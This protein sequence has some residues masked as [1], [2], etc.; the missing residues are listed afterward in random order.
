MCGW[1]RRRGGDTGDGSDV[2]SPPATHAHGVAV[3]FAQRD[4][5][6][7]ANLCRFGCPRL[8]RT[9]WRRRRCEREAACGVTGGGADVPLAPSDGVDES[10]IAAVRAVIGEVEVE[11]WVG[12]GDDTWHYNSQL[13][14]Q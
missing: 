13:I 7:S 1:S 11:R 14:S 12:G 10:E 6:A 3:S 5:N 9:W 8:E 4:A 2:Q